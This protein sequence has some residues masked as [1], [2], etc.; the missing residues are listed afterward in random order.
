MIIATMGST[1][2]FGID[3]LEAIV[4]MRDRLVD[5]FKLPYKPHVH[6][7]AVIGWAWSVFND[8]CYDENVLEFRGRTVRALA[9]AQ[10]KIRHLHLAD[11]MGIDYHKTGYA[12]YVSSAVL[13]KDTNDLFSLRRSKST[14]PYLYTSGEYHPGGI[15]PR[16][17]TKRDRPHG[18]PG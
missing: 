7:D 2:A 9:A 10:R 11:S 12:P 15:Y 4:A 8:Y 13:F 14:M 5:E 3:N 16:D 17:F 6:V 18:C 1:D